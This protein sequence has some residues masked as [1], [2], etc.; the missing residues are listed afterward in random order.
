MNFLNKYKFIFA[1]ILPVLILVL[2]RAFGS[3]HFQSDAKKWAEPSV[4]L[5]NIITGEKIGTL[6]GEK[7]IISLGNN[8]NG[9]KEITG[10]ALIIPADSILSKNNLYIIRNHNGPVLL[11]SSDVSVSARI[12]ML[13]RQMGCNNIYIFTNYPDN[14]VFKNKFQPDTLVRP[15]L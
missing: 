5:S 12:W 8:D 13:L 9:I 1:I 7:L 6:P 14:E 3:N 2:F 15:E 11:F 10:N 4:V